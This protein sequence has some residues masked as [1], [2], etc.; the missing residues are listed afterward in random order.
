M[1]VARFIGRELQNQVAR[2]ETDIVHRVT[3]IPTSVIAPR[4][5]AK[6]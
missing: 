2:T 5:C 1:S 4:R 6:K 3:V